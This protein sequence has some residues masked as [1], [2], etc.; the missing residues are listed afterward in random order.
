[1]V[2]IF[3]LGANLTITYCLKFGAIL[4]SWPKVRVCLLSNSFWVISSKIDFFGVVL[5]YLINLVAHVFLIKSINS[6]APIDP[7][8]LVDLEKSIKSIGQI[9]MENYFLISKLKFLVKLFLT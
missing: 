7:I 8:T 4:K 3:L 5:V 1:M 2:I 9:D 6:V